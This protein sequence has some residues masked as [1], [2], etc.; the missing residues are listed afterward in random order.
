[1]HSKARS[2]QVDIR[3]IRDP[4]LKDLAGLARLRKPTTYAS[5]FITFHPFTSA[6]LHSDPTHPTPILRA[7]TSDTLRHV[8]TL[9]T[10]LPVPRRF[11]VATRDARRP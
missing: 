7:V 5:R 1:M 8:G 9:P 11:H 2:L 4:G 6:P 10:R 3:E